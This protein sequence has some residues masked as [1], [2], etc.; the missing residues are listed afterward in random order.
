MT[1]DLR[2]LWAA[3]A[4]GLPVT[5]YTRAQMVFMAAAGGP[6]WKQFSE[7]PALQFEPSPLSRSEGEIPV[8]Y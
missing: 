1:S 6:Q 7:G 2:L 8:G 3:A 5:W 4:T